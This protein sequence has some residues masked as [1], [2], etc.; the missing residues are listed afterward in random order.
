MQ[1]YLEATGDLDGVELLNGT[2]RGKCFE[3]SRIFC[4][5]P[6]GSSHISVINILSANIYTYIQIYMHLY[7]YSMKYSYI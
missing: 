6:I 2:V 4:T 3:D 1:T 5:F 7:I